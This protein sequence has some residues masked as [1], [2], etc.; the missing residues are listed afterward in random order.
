ME[1]PRLAASPCLRPVNRRRFSARLSPFCPRRLEKVAPRAG[2][3]PA[4][5]RLTGGKSVGSRPLPQCAGRCRIGRRRSENR[6]DFRV[7]LCAALCRGLP[8]LGAPK[9]QEKG[10][11]SEKLPAGRA[12]RVS[13][14]DRLHRGDS[15]NRHTSHTAI[16][17]ARDALW[18]TTANRSGLRFGISSQRVLA[19]Q[20][21]AAQLV[22]R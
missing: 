5:L 7:S 19:N 11:V 1:Q 2:L 12:D 20:L 15:R 16:L 8:L 3:E 9:G 21:S 18:Q 4:T 6:N 22:S 17:K 10:N 14:K 13:A